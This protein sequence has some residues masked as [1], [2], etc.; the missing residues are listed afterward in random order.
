MPAITTGLRCGQSKT[1]PEPNC[2]AKDE[3]SSN[4]NLAI[5]KPDLSILLPNLSIAK[6]K[7]SIVEIKEAVA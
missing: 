4:P 2:L 3:V 7:D 5:A 6:Q 1:A